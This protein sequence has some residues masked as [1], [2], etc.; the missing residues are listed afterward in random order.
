[1]HQDDESMIAAHAAN[2]HRPSP[3]QVQQWHD[4]IDRAAALERGKETRSGSSRS[5]GMLLWGAALGAAVVLGVAIGLRWSDSSPTVTPS[6]ITPALANA[7]TTTDATP[8]AFTRGLSL[9]LRESQQSISRFD[10]SS[11]SAQLIRDIVQQNRRF[12]AV[13]D[14]HD[15]DNIARVLRAFEP[16][17]LRLAAEDIA[18][19]DANALREQLEFELNVMLTKLSQQSSDQSHST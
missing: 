8:V 6:S 15:A 7:P 14:Q 1:M 13:A 18:P 12:E 5:R 3:H 19:G 9:H 11:D 10:S 17:L 2:T 4:T 16:V